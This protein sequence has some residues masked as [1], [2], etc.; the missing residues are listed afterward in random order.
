[1]RCS[2]YK[3]PTPWVSRAI[4][5]GWSGKPHLDGDRDLTPRLAAPSHAPHREMW[6][7]NTEYRRCPYGWPCR[8]V[9]PRNEG[10]VRHGRTDV[11]PVLL[12]AGK[13]D[14]LPR[15]VLVRDEAEQVR[16]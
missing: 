2:G 16:E 4:R 10:L 5:F 7:P 8:S 15:D 12:P 1:M 3:S 6:S 13:R 11:G 14:L 9:P